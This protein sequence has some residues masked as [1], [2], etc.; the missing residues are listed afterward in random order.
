MGFTF[1]QVA[2][3]AGILATP[4]VV[5]IVDILHQ[6]MNIVAARTVQTRRT[7]HVVSQQIV[8]IGSSLTTP[9]RTITAS[10]LTVTGIVKTFM[11][12][13]P[14]NGGKIVVVNSH[15]FFARPAKG[16]MVDDEVFGIFNTDGTS[17]DKI[18]VAIQTDAETQMTYNQVFTTTEI[19]FGTANTDAISRSRLSGNS[20]T[21]F[22]S[23]TQ[24]GF[25]RNDTRHAEYH[26]NRLVGILTQSPAQT[27]GAGIV[28]VRHFN[29]LS[30]ASTSGPSAVTFGR[31]KCR[32][33][34][35]HIGAN[36]HH[37]DGQ[38]QQ[39]YSFH[40]L[41]DLTSTND[42]VKGERR[43]TSL[44]EFYAEPHPI[45]C[46]DSINRED[47]GRF[48]VKILLLYFIF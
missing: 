5:D 4:V 29:H 17:F 21:G 15:I 25:E 13:T 42:I 18:V 26:R 16:T 8:M 41:I 31:R 14:L 2:T 40:I 1:Y 33:S 32:H 47:N 19:S 11:H 7:A 34:R 12:D 6:H 48:S 46:K 39:F 28:Q 38:K 9:L 30:A 36:Q 27:S 43:K 23:T 45:F 20:G 24:I 37:K 44:L 3:I 10:A 35:Q 22:S